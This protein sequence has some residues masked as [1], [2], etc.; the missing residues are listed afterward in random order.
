VAPARPPAETAVVRP[1]E[2]PVRAR[3]TV[4][5]SGAAATVV[6]P[7]IRPSSAPL[8]SA[9]TPRARVQRAPTTLAVHRPDDGHDHGGAEP[10]TASRSADG[11]ITVHR[12]ADA[13][14]MATALD[15]RSFTHAG[16]I[17]LPASHGPLTSGAGRSLLAHELTHVTQQRR[18]GGGLPQE[19]TPRGQSLE[20]DAVR[21]ER[22]GTL[23]LAVPPAAPLTAAV[24]GPTDVSEKPQRAPLAAS[25]AEDTTTVHLASSVQ[26]APAIGGMGGMQG[27]DHHERGRKRHSEQ[28]LEEL[29]RQLYARIGRRLR[30]E[31]LDDRERAGLAV[32]L[33]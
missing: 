33:V 20:A 16:E 8:V 14:E 27:G 19:E 21:A 2:A 32:D 31:L 24:D 18:M 30:R 7:V 9:Q 5:A 15:A 3:P 29:A 1:S 26:R 25:G 11:P 17:Y 10:T 23:P 22:S 13:A 12:G 6:A 28:E 4:T